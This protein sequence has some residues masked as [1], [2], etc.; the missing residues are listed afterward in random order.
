MKNQLVQY[1]ETTRG[2]S[3]IYEESGDFKSSCMDYAIF[4]S[5]NEDDA[6]MNFDISSPRLV[7]RNTDA[8]K[9]DFLATRI[10]NYDYSH[11][12]SIKAKIKKTEISD[13]KKKT[14][15]RRFKNFFTGLRL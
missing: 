6:S 8:S 13:K 7:V 1:I 12:M 9:D 3:I 4:T 2:F 10:S 5:E 11:R 14:R 15:K